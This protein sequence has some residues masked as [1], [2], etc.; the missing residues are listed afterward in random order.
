MWLKGDLQ[1][2]GNSSFRF[3]QGY[4]SPPIIC[5]PCMGISQTAL[6]AIKTAK[7][8][9]KEAEFSGFF[10]Y[11]WVQRYCKMKKR[12]PGDLFSK[13]RISGIPGISRKLASLVYGGI[14]FRHITC[15]SKTAPCPGPASLTLAGSPYYKQHIHTFHGHLFVRGNYPRLLWPTTVYLD[16]TK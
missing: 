1:D 2:C 16:S 12:K 3:T 4:E 13:I 5:M 14:V 7:L 6:T 15:P 9:Q 10:F 8:L 11:F